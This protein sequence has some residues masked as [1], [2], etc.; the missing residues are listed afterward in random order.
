VRT[1]E[2][3]YDLPPTAIAQAPAEPRD[4]AR[5]LVDRGPGRSPADATVAQLCD[6]LRPGDVVVV[7]D[8]RVLRARVPVERPGGG[9]GE[10]MLLE[11]ASDGWW[12]ALC[13]PSRR[14]QP[15]AVVRSVA[16]ELSVEMGG[17]LEGGRRLVRPIHRGTLVDALEQAGTLP[18]PPYI[19][20]QLD[21]PER[22]QTVYAGRPGS[23]AAPTAGLHLTPALLSRM[24]ALGVTLA[25]VELVVGVDTFRP[26]TAAVVEQHDIHSERYR[27]PPA[28]ID[29]VGAARERGDRVVAVGT[30]S[31][32]ALESLAATGLAEGRTDLFITPGFR[33][34]TVDVLMTNFH[35]PRSSLLAMIEAFAGPHWR[36]LYS[37]ALERGYRFLSFG[38]AMLLERAGR[39]GGS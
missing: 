25:R 38:D 16:G 33:F 10:V 12:Q 3:D 34:R 18:L 13:R 19:T 31:V 21:D 36:D 14:L 23:A 5:L 26:I 37:T 17:S 4:T 15:G 6:H 7:N 32:R 9:L 27:V 20:A 22:Y 24:E 35:M 8:T 28:T 30:T 39:P 29:A 2:L 1:D 11:P